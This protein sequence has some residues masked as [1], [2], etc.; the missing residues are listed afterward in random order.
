MNT[1]QQARP[2]YSLDGI[3]IGTVLGSFIAG[4][5]MVVANYATLGSAALAKRTAIGGFAIY[6]G[7]V[8]LTAFMPNALWVGVVF[9]FVQA[10]LAFFLATQ[11]Q[12]PVLRYQKAQ[13]RAFHGL[14][15]SALVGVLAGLMAITAIV[16]I[17]TLLAGM[18]A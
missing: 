17:G 10:A 2:L 6:V 8:L 16:S 14:L 1:Q 3:V 9:M 18:M 4:V 11:L 7:I 15:R 12:G 13:G 5:F